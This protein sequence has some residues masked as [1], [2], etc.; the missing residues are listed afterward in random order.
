MYR[1]FYNYDGVI[2]LYCHIFNLNY[3]LP[4]DT[5]TFLFEFIRF[6]WTRFYRSHSVFDFFISITDRIKTYTS[7]NNEKVLDFIISDRFHGCELLIS[8]L[9]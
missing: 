3:C 7:K 6:Q 4:I 9:K 8:H 1:Q 2:F 5:E